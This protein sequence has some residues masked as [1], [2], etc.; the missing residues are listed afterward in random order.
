MSEWTTKPN[1]S[2]RAFAL[3]VALSALPGCVTEVTGGLPAPAPTQ[4]RVSAQLDLARGYLE[5]GDLERAQGPLERAL[6]IDPEHVEAHVL[7]AVFYQAEK[8]WELAEEHFESALAVEPSN[9]QALNN[10][11]SFLYSRGRFADAV[12]QLSRLVKDTSYRARS[13]AFENLGLAYTQ[14]GDTP[15]A[16]SSFKRALELGFRQPRSSLELAEIHFKR[17]EL[18]IADR[19]L[20]EYKTYVRQPSARG[21]CLELQLATATEDE[22]RVASSSLALKNLYPKQ[23]GQCQA[24]S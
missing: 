18:A 1:G 11:G 23:A 14:I 7:I 19:R 20:L 3:A 5:Q 10:Y 12:V 4:E 8:E 21:L 16:E 17:G 9:A 24:K 13:Q 15:A 2:V 6:E 22:D